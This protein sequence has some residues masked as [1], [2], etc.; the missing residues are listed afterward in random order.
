MSWTD[1]KYALNS[2][3]GDSDFNPLDKIIEACK[4]EILNQL[5]AQSE[6][7]IANATETF[8]LQKITLIENTTLTSSDD[9]YNLI[10]PKNRSNFKFLT[11]L[12]LYGPSASNMYWHIFVDKNSSDILSKEAI[13][14]SALT[15]LGTTDT[16][17]GNIFYHNDGSSFDFRA[18]LI[19]ESAESVTIRIYLNKLNSGT[20]YYCLYAYYA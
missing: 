7:I 3:L 15:V 8:P 17:K 9:W 14:M 18:D 11:L 12:F 2:K 19:A 1:V 6:D 4:T 5:N 13:K 10:I 16:P 20:S